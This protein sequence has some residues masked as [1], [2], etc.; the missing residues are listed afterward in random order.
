MYSC[1]YTGAYMLP[2]FVVKGKFNYLL[3]CNIGD[4]KPFAGKTQDCL[5]PPAPITK[6]QHPLDLKSKQPKWLHEIRATLLA[7]K[8]N[9]F[10]HVDLRIYIQYSSL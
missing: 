9:R 8:L 3:Q 6:T 5:N 1:D 2:S 4:L 7:V 10:V